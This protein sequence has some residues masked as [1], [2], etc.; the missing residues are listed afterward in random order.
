MLAIYFQ[1]SSYLSIPRV[2]DIGLWALLITCFFQVFTAPDLPRSEEIRTREKIFDAF[3]VLL[4][5]PL[6]SSLISWSY[7]KG[8]FAHNTRRNLVF[9][10]TPKH[11]QQWHLSST[12]HLICL[13]VIG[14]FTINCFYAA[15]MNQLITSAWFFLHGLV[16]TVLWWPS[17]RNTSVSRFLPQ[18][19]GYGNAA[20]KGTVIPISLIG[21]TADSK[22]GEHI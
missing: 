17:F 20:T 3:L 11:E 7:F 1:E 10:S 18:F 19:K 14:F 15:I 12:D 5:C 13:G 16:A 21:S 8:I 4:A 2:V 6:I 9:N 22:K